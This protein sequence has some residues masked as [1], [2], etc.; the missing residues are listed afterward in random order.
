[1]LFNRLLTPLRLF[2]RTVMS[3]D[4]LWC[5]FA[6]ISRHTLIGLL[7]YAPAIVG[8]VAIGGEGSGTGSTSDAPSLLYTDHIV[9][10]QTSARVPPDL[11]RD[12]RAYPN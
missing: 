12:T 9:L 4:G 5:S 10:T 7:Q 1:M 2:A 6:I 8:S 11:P 3:M